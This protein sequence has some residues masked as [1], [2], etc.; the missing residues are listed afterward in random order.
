MAITINT[1]PTGYLPSDNPII[2]RVSSN[3]TAQDDFFFVVLVYVNAVLHS[4]HKVFIESNN[5]AKF[6]FS[7]VAKSICTSYKYNSTSVIQE[8]QNY[9]AFTYAVE[10]WYNG[11]L[12]NVSIS[13]LVTPFYVFKAKLSNEEFVTYLSQQTQ[14]IQGGI[15]RRFLSFRSPSNITDMRLNG[16]CFIGVINNSSSITNARLNLL[17]ENGVIVDFVEITMSSTRIA[18]INLNPVLWIAST[19]LTINEYLASAFVELY[20]IRNDN[21]IRVTEVRKFR[22][23]KRGCY[24]GRQL[25]FLNKFG[26]YESFLFFHNQ[27]AETEIQEHSYTRGFGEWVGDNYVLDPTTSGNFDYLKKM[28]DKVEITSDYINQDQFNWLTREVLESPLVYAQ[29]ENQVPYRVIPR[30]G[31]YRQAQDRFEELFNL[32]INCDLPNVRYSPLI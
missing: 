16:D 1:T 24:F 7:K 5:F 8:N 23:D 29:F 14:Y 6:D 9:K 28:T 20:L 26:S 25:T 22:L 4:R 32:T 19:S 3:Q 27:V 11:G 12:Q 17:D 2:L 13:G 10:E 15:S 18:L 21:G 31:T 30:N